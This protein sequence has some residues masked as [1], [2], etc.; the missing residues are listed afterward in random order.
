[1]CII[2]WKKPI[3]KA[4]IQ[5]DCTDTEIVKKW[6]QAASIRSGGDRDGMWGTEKC[7]GKEMSLYDTGT[8][9][10]CHSSLSKARDYASRVNTMKNRDFAW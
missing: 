5:C 2:N 1:M 4:H 8:A 9:G 3:W 10:S 6:N 7:Q